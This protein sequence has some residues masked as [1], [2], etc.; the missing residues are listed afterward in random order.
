MSCTEPAAS[1]AEQAGVDDL[2]ID[3]R[4]EQVARD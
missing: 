4:E 3:I 1:E 2:W